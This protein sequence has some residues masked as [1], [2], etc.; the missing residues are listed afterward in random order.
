LLEIVPDIQQMCSTGTATCIGS[1]RNNSRPSDI[2]HF[3]RNLGV[4]NI[5]TDTQHIS[6]D[7]CASEDAVKPVLAAVSAAELIQEESG[8]S[9]SHTNLALQHLWMHVNQH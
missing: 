5:A 1:T 8:D 9:I 2:P 4:T 3:S 6:V 7:L